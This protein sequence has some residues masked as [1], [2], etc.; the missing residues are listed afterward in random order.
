[1]LEICQL[2][3][4]YDVIIDVFNKRTVAVDL[5]HCNVPATFLVHIE[6][7][8]KWSKINENLQCLKHLNLMYLY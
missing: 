4:F 6:V 7:Y 3:I 2:D 8:I 1:M 5:L